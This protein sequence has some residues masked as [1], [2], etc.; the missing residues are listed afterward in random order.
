MW[1]KFALVFAT[2]A[3]A[4]LLAVPAYAYGKTATRIVVTKSKYTVDWSTPGVIPTAPVVTAKLQK[5]TSRGWVSL[6]GTVRVYALYSDATSYQYLY[7]K[8]SVTS[9]RQTLA[10]RGR[11]KFYYAGSSTMKS[12]TGY[13]TRVDKIGDTVTLETTD[14]QQ[15]DATWTQV[16]LV[17]NVGWNT[18]AFDGMTGGPLELDFNG[19]FEN[20]DYYSGDTYFYQETWD[21]GAIEFTFRV[22]NDYIPSDQLTDPVAFNSKATLVSNDP[23]I[24][25]SAVAPGSTPWTKV[26]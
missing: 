14:I 18:E 16:H 1:G 6:K 26:D 2:A 5:K 9:V 8:S 17:Y 15:L 23:F 4:A 20:S 7:T 13:T 12:C 3:I 21:P 25:T 11:Y 10:A 24:V 19:T 22:R